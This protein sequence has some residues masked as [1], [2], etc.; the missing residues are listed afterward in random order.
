MAIT[1]KVA[2]TWIALV[3]V[4]GLA[5]GVLYFS[6]ASQPVQDAAGQSAASNDEPPENEQA[7]ESVESP[8]WSDPSRVGE[9]YGN[10]V[11]GL[12]TFRGNPTRTYYG[13]GEV[14]R[15]QPNVAWRYP[16][17]G[18]L[19]G[20]SDPG[21]GPVTWCGTGWTG[22][23]SVFERDDK[24]WLV[25][26]AYDYGVHFLNA[27]TGKPIIPAFKTG[28][29]IKG[30]VTVDPDGYPIVYSGSRDNYLRAISFDGSE[31]KEL[32]KLSA[33]AVS[34]VQWNNDW[35]GS[36]LVIDDYLFEGGEN[37]QLHIVKL[38]RGYDQQGKVTLN[39]KLVFNAPGWDDELLAAFGSNQV[40]IENSVSIYE[41]T[42]YFSNSAGLVQG[43]DIAGLKDGKTPKR[44]FRFWTGDDTDASV[45]IDEQG[46][47]YVAS[48]Y[49]KGNARSREVGQ[50]MKLDPR[51]KQNPLVWSIDDNDY[52]PGGIWGTPALYKDVVIYDTNGGEVAAADRDTGEVR[53][54]KQL[55]GPVW[56][57]PSVVDDV[58]VIG[59]CAGDLHAYDVAD[60][61]V[62]PAKLWTISLG[63]CIES[64]PA[65]WDGGIYLGTR[66][67]GVFGLSADAPGIAVDSGADTGAEAPSGGSADGA[68]VTSN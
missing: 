29:I 55:P 64:T 28:D 9:P 32:W 21:G 51:K 42:L 47:L 41:D 14:T 45:V 57:S 52:N 18:G 36:P 16:K 25:F 53:W 58:L 62:D 5:A 10:E 11:S 17:T 40:S 54:S 60:T 13:G 48:E 24:T 67:G 19:C 6:V 61:T 37:S 66:D 27:E 35:D 4:L 43:W 26:G 65:I 39:P 56:Q 59:D 15:T 38:N 3:A 7:Q 8:Y 46:F 30:S 44:V 31:P 1:S 2:G 33:D 20:L 63:G 12:I 22:Q 50:L 34:P 68:S 49:E 23:P